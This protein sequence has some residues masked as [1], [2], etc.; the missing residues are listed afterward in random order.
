ML[1]HCRDVVE[2]PVSFTYSSIGWYTGFLVLFYSI[3]NRGC[4]VVTRQKFSPKNFGRIVKQYKV[5]NTIFSTESA[6]LLYQSADFNEDD[7]KSV[8][9]C[10]CGGERV[11][12]SIRR[13]MTA[14]LP[15][16]SFAVVY[17]AT[18]TGIYTNFMKNVDLTGIRG[19]IVGK[20]RENVQCK[21][22]D[23]SS[24]KPLGHREIG[25]FLVIPESHF[26]V[27]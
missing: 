13:H 21:V 23:I 17:G 10:N 27:S 4:R 11:P 12:Q 19:S 20:V 25:E 5:T 3:L 26:N 18:E 15:K 2:D 6:T 9:E 8:R 1:I 24:R 22:V 16:G 14:K 7:F